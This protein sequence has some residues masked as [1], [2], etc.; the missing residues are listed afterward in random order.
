MNVYI[1]LMLRQ[2]MWAISGYPRR[3]S[4]RL[5]YTGSIL[6]LRFVRGLRGLISDYRHR[7]SEQ[8]LYAGS[9]P[10]ISDPARNGGIRFQQ[11]LGQ[12]GCCLTISSTIA[13]WAWSKQPRA[14]FHAL[15]VFGRSLSSVCTWLSTVLLS[16]E[17]RSMPLRIDSSSDRADSFDFG[18]A[19][20]GELIVVKPWCSRQHWPHWVKCNLATASISNVCASIGKSRAWF[21]LSGHVAYGSDSERGGTLR[22]TTVP[23]LVSHYAFIRSTSWQL[24][25]YLTPF[26]LAIES[27]YPHP[28]GSDFL[29]K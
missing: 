21:A 25:F 17:L 3:N 1:E 5:L 23:Y 27:E 2:R 10:H 12:Y 16:N 11:P 29:W 6:L 19:L 18:S 28:E 20:A 8:L 9:I 14:P 22:G 13:R 24:D 4:E 15:W 7:S 26:C